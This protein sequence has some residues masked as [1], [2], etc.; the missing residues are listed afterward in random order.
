MCRIFVY[1]CICL[2]FGGY[3]FTIYEYLTT[4][5]NACNIWL[6]AHLMA[7]WNMVPEL[8]CWPICAYEGSMLLRHG[9]WYCMLI[10][11]RFCFTMSCDALHY[12][13]PC[14]V[15]QYHTPCPVLFS[16]LCSALSCPVLSCPVLFWPVLFCSV[17]SCPALFCPVLSCPVLSCPALTCSDLYCSVLF[18]P[19]MSCHVLPCPALTCLVLNSCIM[20]CPVSSQPKP[21]HLVSCN[22]I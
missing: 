4:L 11:F 13:F 3:I 17:L 20:S 22:L 1:V 2:L 9:V 16:D 10:Y 21:Y 15:Q 5:M 14:L 12:Y 7:H 18:C 8:C 6:M 19:V